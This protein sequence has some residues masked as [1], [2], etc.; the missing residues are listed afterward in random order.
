[1]VRKV[2]TCR[3]SQNHCR[4]TVNLPYLYEA[5]AAQPGAASEMKGRRHLTRY[6]SEGPSRGSG[7]MI[8]RERMLGVAGGPA[9]RHRLVIQ[10]RFAQSW[11]EPHFPHRNHLHWEVDSRRRSPLSGLNHQTPDHPCS[12]LQPRHHLL[13]PALPAFYVL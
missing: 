13:W 5:K 10:K 9:F 2:E 1:M 12:F 3:Q 11:A 6:V 7:E 8:R 4:Q